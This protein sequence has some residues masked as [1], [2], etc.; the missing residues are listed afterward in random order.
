MLPQ[1]IID[2]LKEVYQKYIKQYWIHALIG[3]GIGGWLFFLFRYFR[4]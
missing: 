2:I 1:E 3:A 4:S